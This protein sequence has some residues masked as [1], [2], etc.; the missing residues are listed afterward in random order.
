VKKIREGG[1]IE[2]EREIERADKKITGNA[3]MHNLYIIN[4]SNEKR[5]TLHLMTFYSYQLV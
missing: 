3:V 1:E 4:R 2:R 5:E